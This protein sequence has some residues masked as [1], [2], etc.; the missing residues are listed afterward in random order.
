MI[1][2]TIGNFDAVSVSCPALPEPFPKG[3]SRFFYF[4]IILTF[5]LFFPIVALFFP[6]PFLQ[7]PLIAFLSAI[8]GLK[9]F[10][11]KPIPSTA[12]GRAPPF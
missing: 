12:P 2:K 10:K 7:I 11:S 5:A 1:N 6:V 4:S 9:F 8:T 3:N